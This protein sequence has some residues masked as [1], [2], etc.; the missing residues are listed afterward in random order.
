M[1]E[2]NPPIPNGFHAL[3]NPNA[4]KFGR[5]DS[6]PARGGDALRA[7]DWSELTA[8]LNAARDLRRELRQEAI[9]CAGASGASFGD[10]EC[11]IH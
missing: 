5:V 6:L 7:I 4:P 11:R 10:A 1:F 2:N 8:R 9:L 3:E